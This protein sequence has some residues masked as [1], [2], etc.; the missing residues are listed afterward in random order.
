MKCGGRGK[1][2]QAE[3]RRAWKRTRDALAAQWLVHRPQRERGARIFERLAGT[4]GEVATEELGV[5]GR[6]EMGCR[7]WELHPVILPCSGG[8]PGVGSCSGTYC[9]AT[10]PPPS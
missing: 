10:A 4:Y 9:G 8:R 3:G 5:K 7:S 2:F 6:E 1:A